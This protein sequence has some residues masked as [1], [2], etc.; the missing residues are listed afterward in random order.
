MIW[1]QTVAAFL[2]MILHGVFC[3]GLFEVKCSQKIWK[4]GET[5]TLNC[6]LTKPPGEI[7]LM[8]NDSYLI[9]S[10]LHTQETLISEDRKFSIV[11]T[12]EWVLVT[13]ANVSFSDNHRYLLIITAKERAG[14][15][16]SGHIWINVS[17]ICTPKISKNSE[18][19][20]KCEAES[21]YKASIDWMDEHRRLYKSQ[22][23]MEHEQLT[24]GF[25]LRSFLQLRD[26]YKGK[27]ICCSVSY[28]INGSYR[29][30]E[31]CTSDWDPSHTSAFS[32]KNTTVS[33]VMIF[34]AAS[35]VVAV[36]GYLLHR[37]KMTIIKDRRIS[38]GALIEQET[39][40][41]EKTTLK[42]SPPPQ[43]V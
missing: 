27:K 19:E 16:H 21:E 32:V 15:Y 8:D 40:E 6:T 41:E 24:T 33:V 2:L 5:L 36:L 38:Q 18:N 13:I 11:W 34:L 12:E 23:T 3:G 9:K 31:T 42:T 7:S 10:D 28:R 39:Y 4:C 35:A 43:D 37:R 22:R 25:T 14:G 30:K 26:E 29:V 20:L 1:V 17:G